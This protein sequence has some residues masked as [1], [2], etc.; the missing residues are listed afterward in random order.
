MNQSI[1]QISSMLWRRAGML[2]L[3]CLLTGFAQG[4]SSAR[5]VDDHLSKVKAQTWLQDDR[6]GFVENKGQFKDQHG[7]SNP[8]VKYLLH[9]TGLNVQLRA[10]GFSY[11]AYLQEENPGR[12]RKNK[13]SG[14]PSAAEANTRFH[15]VD[16]EL[17]GANPSARLVAVDRLGATRNVINEWGV[18]NGIRSYKTVIYKDIYPGIDLEFVATKGTDKPVEYNFIVHPGADAARIKMRYNNGGDITLKE[19]K[20]EMKLAFGT[21]KEKIPASFTQQDGKSLAVQYIA[22]DEAN[23]LYAFN[24]PAYDKRKTLVI[25]PTPSLVWSTYYGGTTSEYIQSIVLD[26][27][28]NLYATGYTNSTAGIATTAAHQTTYAGTTDAFLTKFSAAGDLLWGT[29]YGGAQQESAYGI[30]YDIAGAVYITGYSTSTAG[31]S[32]PGAF[33]VNK[34]T[35]VDMFLAK[36]DTSGIRQWG[37]YYGG[38]ASTGLEYGYALAIGKDRSVYMTGGVA[39]SG[40][41]SAGAYRTTSQGGV[42]VILAK[43]NPDGTRQWATYYGGA[44]QE[45]AECIALDNNDN[46]YIGGG[47]LSTGSGIAANVSEGQSTSVRSGFLAKFSSAGAFKWGRFYGSLASNL[48][49]GLL[50]IAFDSVNSALYI[51]GELIGR[52]PTTAL[53]TPGAFQEAS[54]TVSSY[55]I[56]Y[57]ARLDTNGVRVWGTFVGSL[58]ST[59]SPNFPSMK[60]DNKGNVYLCQGTLAAD[61]RLTTDCSFQRANAGSRDLLINKFSPAGS[62]I[63]GSY[64]GTATTEFPAEHGGFAI[65]PNGDIYMGG[66]CQST[67]IITPGAYKT[68]APSTTAVNMFFAKLKQEYLPADLIISPNTIAPLTQNTCILGIP[69]VIEGTAVAITN[70]DPG[71]KSPVTYQWQGADAATGPWT[72]LLGEV[73]KDL[74]PTASQ[75][76]RYYRR[77]VRANTSYCNYEAV[78]GSVSA[79]ATVTITTDAAPVANANGPQWYL[80]GS[81]NSITLTGGAAPVGP[82]YT[83]QWFA[84]N[85]TT[86]IV[87]TPAGSNAVTVTGITA[88]TTYTLKIIN[89]TTGCSDIDQTTITPVPADAGGNKPLCAG[90]GGVQ[91]GTPPVASPNITYAWTLS[92]SGSAAATLSC[93]NCAQPIANPAAATTYLLT[94]SVL[95][96]DGTTCSTTSTTTVTPVAAPGSNLA[97]AGADQT[98]CK[99]STTTLGIANDAAVS[100]YTWTPGQY[101]SASNIAQPVFNAGTAALKCNQNYVV[102]AVKSGCTFTD[103]VK[104]SVLSSGLTDPSTSAAAPVCGPLWED[105]TGDGDNCGTAT[106]AWSVVSGTGAVLQTRN[107]GKG[108]YLSSSSGVTRF[109]RTTTLN[110]VSCSADV[111][112]Q[113]CAG[114]ATCAFSI[115]ASASQGCAKV[116]AGGPS[117]KLATGLNPAD[118]NFTWSPAG[119]VDSV[120]A[121]VVTVTSAVHATIYCTI[122]NK[123]DPSIV[124]TKSIVVNNPS[125]SLPVF[126]TQNKLKCPASLINIGAPASAGFTYAWT[127]LSGSSDLNDPTLANPTTSTTTDK[128][129]MVTVRETAT[130]CVSRDTVEVGVSQVIAIVQPDRTV[131]NGGT[132]KLGTTRPAIGANWTYSWQP[133]NAAWAPGSGPTDVQPQVVFATT[134]QKFTLTVT[135][136]ASGCTAMDTVTLKSTVTAGEF[137]GPAKAACEGTT[138]QLGNPATDATAVYTWTR[139]SGAAA[140]ELSC[141]NCAQPTLTVPSATTTY[142][143]TVAYPGCNTP[144]SDQVTVTV[145]AAP[146]FTLTDRTICPSAATA[147]GIGA[148]GN[149][150]SLANVSTYAWT[151]ATNLS[152][153]AIA[154]PTSNVTTLTTYTL[155]VTYTNGCT[156]TDD[157]VVTPNSTANAKPDAAICLGESTQI[158][159][160]AVSGATYSWSPATDITSAANIA[161]PTVKPTTTRTYT[162]SVTT[163]GCTATDAVIVTVNAPADF[164]IAG[165]T[166]ICEGGAT[167]LG[168]TAAAPNTTWQWTP[169]TGIASPNS[170]TTVVTANDTT[171]YRLIQTNVLTGCSNYKEV[172]LVVKPNNIAATVA[173]ANACPGV[174]TNLPAITVTPAGAYQYLWSPATGLSNGY[175]AN[176]TVNTGVDRNYILTVTDNVSKCQVVKN[177]AVSMLPETACY[178]AVTLTGNVF[179]DGNGLNNASVDSTSP[180][181]IPGGLYVTLVDTAGNAVK[182]VAV[183]ANGTYDFG[184]TAPGT[185]NIVMHQTSTGSTT[186]NPPNGWMN[187]GEH[188]GAGSGN[189]EA[190]NGILTGVI[191]TATNVNNANFGIQQPPSSDPQAYVI[192]PPAINTTRP[193]TG[194][195]A[196]NSPGPL[197]GYDGEDGVKGTGATFIITDTTGLNGNQ[198]Y[199]NNVIVEPGVPIPGYNPAL[200]SIK[201]SGNGSASLTF[202]YA[203]SDNAGAT[204]APVAYSVSWGSALPLQL[205]AFTATKNTATTATLQWTTINEQNSSQFIVERSTD[206]LLWE[207]IG[208]AKAAGNSREQKQYG[209]SD[210]KPQQGLNY[211]RLRMTDVQGNY[212]LSAIRQLVFNKP[213]NAM[214]LAPNPSDGYATLRFIQPLTNDITIKVWNSAGQLVKKQVLKTGQQQC[215]L[216]LNGEGKGLYLILVN[217]D[218][219]QDQIKLLLK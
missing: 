12:N 133:S 63:W 124:C 162:V 110:G 132:I 75:T 40:M 39:S 204:S 55:W 3:A 158:G 46:I 192:A 48:G 174:T 194:T 190:T 102:T 84:G 97:F 212:T 100:S 183:L 130:G 119:M 69:A 203:V 65:A 209:L 211:Y 103:E 118:Y 163:G 179:H 198:L 153:T 187:A 78:P 72:D 167:T 60:V 214:T 98:I 178:P 70:A 68:V 125:W 168:T 219:L 20:I 213:G 18:F 59:N 80:C 43:F 113:P 144:S 88:P 30:A 138:I 137:A 58:N 210:N 197:S 201:F 32:T 184:V 208:S 61:T 159:T 93:V 94:V 129:Y 51:A 182:T 67:T 127:T 50:S 10:T 29:Y 152:N 176:P 141:S 106:Y 172:I 83:Y 45:F 112:V 47:T 200:L 22:T 173:D 121:A 49:D 86:P 9:L 28:N 77:V 191:I 117:F 148:S 156:R 131:C 73:S 53:T 44:L 81:T 66:S 79:V 126:T 114:P 115:T 175:I 42:D 122:T 216:D 215:I 120:H 145:N 160:P 149:T 38:T 23:N 146:V 136:P 36:F 71:Y 150:A 14:L 41:A 164:T 92:P 128:T 195:G 193:L 2:V 139:S 34:S 89:T 181:P 35:D 52:A 134:S 25:D 19:G 21:L 74:Q 199:Y 135:D 104:V 4:Q 54:P 169:T 123:Y 116:F 76:T 151:P 101:L 99:N 202:S 11:D 165:N 186:P 62:M 15:R 17:E 185:Y 177:I 171:T 189:D 91:I 140:P 37:T 31:I 170:P 206:A 143:V 26:E 107:G 196:A 207:P 56:S 85:A 166:T 218:D 180:A 33:Q 57:L 155:K 96:K 95:Q 205:L 142:K 1:V 157:L 8:S 111:Y 161:Q 147:I 105:G 6:A 188:M 5:R 217:G 24:V 64:F 13:Q 27:K 16:I 87:T 7:K 154:N 108:A 109:R 90:T 82:T